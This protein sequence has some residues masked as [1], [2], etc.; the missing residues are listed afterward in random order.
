MPLREDVMPIKLNIPKSLDI[1]RGLRYNSKYVKEADKY[2]DCISVDDGDVDRAR[3][4]LMA[5]L[6]DAKNYIDYLERMHGDTDG[7]A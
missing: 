5:A 3:K 4:I 6:R 7:A 2:L 1:S